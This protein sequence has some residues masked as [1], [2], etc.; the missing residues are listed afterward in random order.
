MY[1]KV[2]FGLIEI[3]T[4]PFRNTNQVNLEKKNLKKIIE[5]MDGARQLNDSS[6]H[7]AARYLN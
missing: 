6:G 5:M 7:K 3:R 4:Q 1:V 2:I